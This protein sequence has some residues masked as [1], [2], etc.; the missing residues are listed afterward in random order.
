LTTIRVI[1]NI[2]IA[3]CFS[4]FCIAQN[5]ADKNYYLVD[6]LTLENI[7]AAEK[8]NLNAALKAFHQAKD[9]TSKLSA[10]SL[11]IQ[12]SLDDNVWP[13]YNAWLHHFV[14]GKLKRANTEEVNLVFKKYLA[15]TY[16]DFGQ[17]FQY[18]GKLLEALNNYN[19]ALKIHK[20]IGSKTGIATAY[21]NIAIIYTNQGYQD[22]ALESF[23]KS[24]SIF[25]EINSTAETST[26]LNNIGTIYLSKGDLTEALRFSK[27]ALQIA[28]KNNNKSDQACSLN[29][30][31]EI[32]CIQTND[33]EGLEY[34]LQSLKINEEIGYKA[35]ASVSLTNIG[36]YY[37]RRNDIEKAKEYGEKNFILSKQIGYPANILIAARL[38]HDIYVKE[39]QY[40]KALEM[41]VLATKM[42]DSLNN[43]AV[44]KLIIEE[45]E[46]NK[47]TT[48]I[49][50]QKAEHEKQK[51]IDL[52]R[53]QKERSLLI[54]CF[55]SIMTVSG[56]LYYRNHTRLN[57]KSQLLLKEIELLKENALS[58]VVIHGK[59][60]SDLELNKEVIESHIDIKLNQTDWRI[61]NILYQNPV[62]SNQEL[63]DQISL[64]I[65]G[66]GSSLKKM[67]LHFDL[68]DTKRSQKK[69]ELIVTASRLSNT[70]T[71]G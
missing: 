47:Y 57:S 7:S 43:T 38:L 70:V 33:V 30:I 35:W 23:L 21:N 36:E 19:R 29:N 68:V 25:N 11:F 34:F 9:D 65:D 42:K 13:K 8:T 26:I 55:I 27:E 52:L 28:E 22:K 45:Q 16:N 58:N 10:L 62:I 15:A 48:K 3:L 44:K 60:E 69:L 66:V 67:Y 17:I 46:K 14:K 12:T 32:L 40:E 64:S 59:N 51:E 20:E 1:L 49:A 41:H 56:F 54:I 61:L 63:A 50:I 39:E 71:K 6:S 4:T 5:F 37:L 31:G 24:L 18:E 2:L 53:N